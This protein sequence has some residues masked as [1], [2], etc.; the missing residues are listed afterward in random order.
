MESGSGGFDIQFSDSPHIP[1]GLIGVGSPTDHLNDDSTEDEGS[2]SAKQSELGTRGKEGKEKLETQKSKS[3]PPAQETIQDE[4]VNELN[5]MVSEAVKDIAKEAK[6]ETTDVHKDK[7]EPEEVKDTSRSSDAMTEVGGDKARI[8]KG[9]RAQVEEDVRWCRRGSL[10]VSK[11]VEYK[12]AAIRAKKRLSNVERSTLEGEGDVGKNTEESAENPGKVWMHVRMRT[13]KEQGATSSTMVLDCN[14]EFKKAFEEEDSGQKEEEED[15]S[16]NKKGGKSRP[17]GGMVETDALSLRKRRELNRL[18][19]DMVGAENVFDT[20]ASG[21]EEGLMQRR[22]RRAKR[23]RSPV[24]SYLSDEEEIHKR[25]RSEHREVSSSLHHAEH[26]GTHKSIEKEF[27][28]RISTLAKLAKAALPPGTNVKDIPKIE[29]P[30]KQKQKV[31]RRRSPWTV[32]TKRRSRGGGVA[33]KGGRVQNRTAHEVGEMHS[34]DDEMTEN[35]ADVSQENIPAQAQS[36]PK[37]KQSPPKNQQYNVKKGSVEPEIA[38]LDAGSAERPPSKYHIPSP[39]R[40]KTRGKRTNV[41]YMV[42]DYIEFSPEKE[43]PP[44]NPKEPER[45]PQEQKIVEI[46]PDAE[47]SNEMDEDFSDR[48]ISGTLEELELYCKPCSV[49]AVDFIRCLDLEQLKNSPGSTSPASARGA[50][51]PRVTSP[52]Y[53]GT[54]TSA[55]G[56]ST[57]YHMDSSTEE[58]E[59]DGTAEDEKVS[60]K[61][62]TVGNEIKKVSK[63]PSTESRL[64]PEKATTPYEAQFLSF[65]NQPDNQPTQVVL[66]PPAKTAQTQ[67]SGTARKG[68]PRVL[69]KSI[70][71]QPQAQQQQQPKQES[72]QEVQGQLARARY[73]CKHCTYSNNSRTVMQEHIYNHTA[74]VPYS[75]GYCSAIF[76]TKSGVISHNKREHMNAPPMVIKTNEVKEED[77][78]YEQPS[79]AATQTQRLAQAA[80][81]KRKAESPAVQS[82]QQRRPTARKS[83]VRPESQNNSVVASILQSP[84]I[85]ARDRDTPSP[86][87]SGS[88]K[89]KF[90]LTRDKKEAILMSEPNDE[91]KKT[92]NKVTPRPRIPKF[93][94]VD[95]NRPYYQCRH[96]TFATHNL[97]YIE[98]HVNKEHA[99][100]QRYVCPLCDLAYC[101]FEDGEFD[102]VMLM[103]K[104]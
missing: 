34:E 35:E 38:K 29:P 26:R 78:Y 86:A 14:R 33:S 84:P 88:L 67:S 36:P 50:T 81:V 53:Q 73:C 1:L 18:K 17:K 12:A 40:M 58:D 91:A 70:Q 66:P 20:V 75:C 16:K 8:S 37:Q 94:Q 79:Q 45:K 10:S 64:T 57:I 77:Y 13:P 97:L 2:D 89:M 62:K 102:F 69:P 71:P 23:Q 28:R 90:S 21:D 22:T 49:V 46:L 43:L 11:P 101:K 63:E 44:V 83:I 96:C 9:R 55:A 65:L 4:V 93:E 32:M 74:V 6:R 3:E 54:S 80:G 100:D 98:S 41:L 51:S 61:G 31:K 42:Q 59:D 7:T 92:I 19:T 87:S 103:V 56:G 48:V 85:T 52:G 72:S 104:A 47:D 24:D 82:T 95:P 30:H 68:L 39:T 15:E 60:K 27:K 25:A 99:A 76:G 5:A